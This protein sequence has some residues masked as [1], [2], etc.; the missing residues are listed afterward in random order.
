MGLIASY[1]L[2][3]L[4]NSFEPG[5]DL[6][7][8]LGE[9]G[10]VNCLHGG[11][12]IDGGNLNAAALILLHDDVTGQHGP[13][14][15]LKSQGAICELR[16]ASAEN[17]IGAKILAELRL[18]RGSHVDIGK[19]AETLALQRLDHARNCLIEGSVESFGEMV[20]HRSA[21]I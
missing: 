2:Q 17:P 10:I 19:D 15:V 3:V 16:V 21:H 18:E 13:D 4:D 12:W 7:R 14:L 6:L 9:A 8:H 1:V 5:L 20:A 11:D